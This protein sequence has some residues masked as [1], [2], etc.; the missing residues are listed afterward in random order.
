MASLVTATYL[1]LH[2]TSRACG[3]LN[4]VRFAHDVTIFA[5]LAVI[6]FSALVFVVNLST[7]PP[8]VAVRTFEKPVHSAIFFQLQNFVFR[9]DQKQSRIYV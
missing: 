6:L 3:L 2:A 7:F 4:P 9:Q 5:F 8:A 1:G